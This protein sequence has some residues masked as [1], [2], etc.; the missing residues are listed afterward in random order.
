MRKLSIVELQSFIDQVTC[1]S[2]EEDMHEQ[3][4]WYVTVRIKLTTTYLPKN[5]TDILRYQQWRDNEKVDVVRYAFTELKKSTERF[6]FKFI[7]M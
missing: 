4:V 6:F 2:S 7:R 3:P 5:P 1:N